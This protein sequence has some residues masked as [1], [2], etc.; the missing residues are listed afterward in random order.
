MAFKE[1]D[2]VNVLVQRKER[3]ILLNGLDVPE[4]ADLLDNDLDSF[5]EMP[6]N[7]IARFSVNSE[8]Q[9][10]FFQV[11]TFRNH[12]WRHVFELILGSAR[13]V[14]NFWPNGGNQWYLSSS[15]HDSS[16]TY[17][18]DLTS[19]IILIFLYKVIKY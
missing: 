5:I 18:F 1:S 4:T 11:I 9:V 2:N 17:V 15:I 7:I 6:F 10:L 8:V 13:W 16:A 14:N 3:K 19:R 12:N